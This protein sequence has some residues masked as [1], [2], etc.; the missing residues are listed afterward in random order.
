MKRIWF[1][2]LSVLMLISVSSALGQSSQDDIAASNLQFEEWS[3]SLAEFV[4][5]IRFN[6][7]DIQS[8][9]SLADDFNSFGTEDD[10]EDGEYIDFSTILN[11]S[12]YLSWA[13]SKGINSEMWLKKSMRIVAVMMRTEMEENS[14]EEQFD[15]Q[16]QLEE[17]EKMRDQI[18]EENYQ[19][20]V[21]AMTAASAAM[22]GLENAYKNLP[23]PTEAEKTLLAKY[24]DQ[25][26]SVE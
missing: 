7:D 12:E 10:N 16:D 21:Q 6:E 11:D 26:M 25:L 1:L 2:L 24:K 15:M 22:Q 3:K 23:V 19:Q 9:I 8:F 14:P 4:K 18:G 20:A 17:L 13:R 5:D